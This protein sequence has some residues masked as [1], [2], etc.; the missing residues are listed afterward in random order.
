[1][2][3]QNSAWR[4]KTGL[5]LDPTGKP[6]EP[7]AL[8]KKGSIYKGGKM[9]EL[10][11][12]TKIKFKAMNDFT[13]DMMQHEGRVEGGPKE[14]KKIQPIEYG[15]LPDDEEIYLVVREDNFGNTLRHVVSVDEISEVKEIDNKE[16]L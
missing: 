14:I 15:E 4:K 16:A 10:K 3:Y 1:M 5:K 13:G 6:L 9:K 8:I 2:I 11:K 7:V 12:G